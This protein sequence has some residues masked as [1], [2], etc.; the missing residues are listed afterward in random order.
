MPSR[1]GRSLRVE[2]LTHVTLRTSRL[3]RTPG[4]RLAT[5]DTIGPA[6]VSGRSTVRSTGATSTATRIRIFWR[7]AFRSVLLGR[8]HIHVR[9]WPPFVNT[10]NSRNCSKIGAQGDRAIVAEDQGVR[11]G[12]AWFRLWTDDCHSYGFVDAK[13]PEIGIAASADQRSRTW[14]QVARGAHPDGSRRRFCAFKFE[15]QSA[16]LCE[17]LWSQVSAVGESG[18]RILLLTWIQSGKKPSNQPDANPR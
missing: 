10:L 13:T 12:A 3:H 16:K 17:A 8:G 2:Q 11:L 4:L 18:T 1:S 14:P 15:R 6:S 5:I 7:D 9:H